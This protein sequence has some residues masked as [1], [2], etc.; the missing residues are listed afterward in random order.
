MSVHPVIEE[1]HRSRKP[2]VCDFCG[3]KIVDGGGAGFETGVCA[4]CCEIFDIELIERVEELK[5]SV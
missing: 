1:L 5:K 4:D 2:L 3:E